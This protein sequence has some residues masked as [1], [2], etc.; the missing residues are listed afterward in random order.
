MSNQNN[1]KILYAPHQEWLPRALAHQLEAGSSTNRCFDGRS[2]GAA[3]VRQVV[4]SSNGVKPVDF[5]SVL[6][7]DR[8][9]VLA[10]HQ[11]A[12]GHGRLVTETELSGR[13]EMEAQEEPIGQMLPP[14]FNSMSIHYWHQRVVMAGSWSTGGVGCQRAQNHQHFLGCPSLYEM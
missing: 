8:H 7:D 10:P 3:V 1:E 12:S 13:C 6:A 11:E 2:H 14:A 4:G 5:V 9:G